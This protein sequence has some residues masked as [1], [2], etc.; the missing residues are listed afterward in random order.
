MFG[1][2]MRDEYGHR[3]ENSQIFQ[4]KQAELDRIK[5][6]CMTRDEVIGVFNW[7]QWFF[8]GGIENYK[9]Y[10]KRLA[11][12]E[13]WTKREREEYDRWP[14]YHNDANNHL[15]VFDT[16]PGHP[17]VQIIR[18]LQLLDLPGE[19]YRRY[20][21]V[22]E[23][24]R[25]LV[26]VMTGEIDSVHN[27]PDTRYH[28]TKDWNVFPEKDSGIHY[29]LGG[30][31][32]SLDY[33]TLPEACFMF[34]SMVPGTKPVPVIK[35]LLSDLMSDWPRYS[36]DNLHHG[37]LSIHTWMPRGF[38]VDLILQGMPAEHL[39]GTWAW[40]YMRGG[41]KDDE[42]YGWF[43]K[44][45]P[46][47][48]VAIRHGFWKIVESRED[49]RTYIDYLQ[50]L[51]KGGYDMK[52]PKYIAPPNLQEAHDV[53]VEVVN[54]E[55]IR[56]LEAQRRRER[57]VN[58]MIAEEQISENLGVLEADT[59][60]YRKKHKKYLEKTWTSKE[61]GLVGKVLQ[62]VPEFLRVGQEMQFCIFSAGYYTHDS[63]LV[64]FVR[65][66][67]PEKT[68]EVAEVNSVDGHVIQCHG[69]RNQK[70]QY[71]NEIIETI[72]NDRLGN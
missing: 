61:N 39:K 7:H 13:W 24:G 50:M 10:N 27:F 36:P 64:R 8:P 35:R 49:F 23:A 65:P 18:V 69:Y 34:R 53:M 40:Q 72:E 71:H 58:A 1:N 57:L 28:P 51:Q 5:E 26:N 47:I 56:K 16:N 14:F 31:Y 60:E 45:W 48:R 33:S 21:R 43:R 44:F 29:T 46:T 70:T 42:L 6:F 15:V 55:T 37:E 20:Y 17:E 67:E 59:K 9:G 32:G 11:P 25:H 52:N 63:Y 3:Y 4:T 38:Q 22:R 41:H 30:Y 68:I 2:E 12:R 54:R 62:D 66:A 19:G